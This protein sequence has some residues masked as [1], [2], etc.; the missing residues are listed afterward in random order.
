MKKIMPILSAL[1]LICLLLLTGCGGQSAQPSPETGE[2][3]ETREEE[4]TTEEEKTEETQPS[5]EEKEKEKAKEEEEAR[6]KIY[7]YMVEMANVPW[8]PKETFDLST[9]SKYLQGL[10]FIAGHR[11]RGAPYE[12]AIDGDMEGFIALLEDG[13]YTGPTTLGQAYGN[14][15][16]S[17][18]AAAWRAAF[19]DIRCDQSVRMLPQKGYGAM[20]VGSYDHTVRTK[21]LT[22][23]ITASSGEQ[24]MYEAYALLKR[25]DAVLTIWGTQQAHVRLVSGEPTVVRANDGSIIGAKSIVTYCDQT[26]TIRSFKGYSSTWQIDAEATFD[27]LFSN[28]Y[29]PVCLEQFYVDHT[30]ELLFTVNGMNDAAKFPSR[31]SGQVGCTQKI[32][33]AKIA[34]LDAE[35]KEIYADEHPDVRSYV[36]RLPEFSTPRLSSAISA[37]PAGKLTFVFSVWT[38]GTDDYVPVHTIEFTK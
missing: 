21:D 26:S 24:V 38:F 19:P 29:I 18:V 8:T 37:A 14:D 17:A 22:T 23:E 10:K 34:L 33:S 27:S 3:E 1:L 4:V 11:Y 12:N 28:D 36:V 6:N 15:C 32:K 2:T 30:R 16:S 9:S 35:G 31:L 20:P 7:D 13:V 25:A 5:P